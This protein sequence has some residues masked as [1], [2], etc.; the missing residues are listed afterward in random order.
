[1]DSVS[2]LESSLEVCPRS[3]NIFGAGAAI[4]YDTVNAAFE[5]VSTGGRTF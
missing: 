3:S 2:L 1:M 4:D 5:A